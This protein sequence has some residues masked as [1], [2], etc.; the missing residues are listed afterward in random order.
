M[1]YMLD[2][3]IIMSVI[4]G[5]HSSPHPTPL[6]A[7]ILAPTTLDLTRAFGTSANSTALDFGAYGAS[8]P[9][10]SIRS[11]AIPSGSAPGRF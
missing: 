6:G 9:G 3:L 1:K 10:A 7:S 5:E 8:A 4:W 2:K 11:L